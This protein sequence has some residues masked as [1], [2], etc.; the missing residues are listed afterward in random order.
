MTARQFRAWAI[1]TEADYDVPSKDNWY[2]MQT[3]CE[4]ARSRMLQPGNVKVSDYKM[5]FGKVDSP[6]RFEETPEEFKHRVTKYMIAASMARL[7]SHVTVRYVNKR[8]EEVPPP[9]A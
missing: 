7:G 4:A 6:D 2:E 8:G 1:W 9:H 3:A 5:K